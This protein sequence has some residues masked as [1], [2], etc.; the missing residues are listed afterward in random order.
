MYNRNPWTDADVE[1]HWDAVAH[2][3]ITENERVKQTHD[4]RFLFSIPQ[5]DLYCNARVLNISSRDCE[6]AVCIAGV[7][8]SVEVTNAE[9]SQKLIGVAAALHPSLTQVK[10]STYSHLPFSN[11]QFD[12]ILTLETLEH[13]ED[14]L[15]FL[16]ELHRVSIP[17]ARMVLSCPP[18]TSELP[19]RIYTALFG[20]H[21]EGPHRFPPSREVK[22]WLKET[23]WDLILHKGTVLLPVGPRWMKNMGETLIGRMQGTFV[24][25]LGIRQFYVCKKY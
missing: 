8:P 10:I 14:P 3:Y 19:Y 4:Q 23:G 25:E 12:R 17:D 11:G 24:A 15:A 13:V 6:A 2:R 22:Q 21:G 18:A 20:G 7:E 5:L 1:A 16:R 9:I